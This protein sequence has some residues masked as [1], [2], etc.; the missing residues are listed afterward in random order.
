MPLPATNPAAP[1]RVCRIRGGQTDAQVAL[2][3]E[4]A[5]AN[6]IDPATVDSTNGFEINY[7]DGLI[8]WRDHQTGR[9]QSS[10]LLI[11]PSAEL[12]TAVGRIDQPAPAAPPVRRRGVVLVD[13]DQ[14]GRLLRLPDDWRVLA[15]QPYPM[16]LAIGLLVEGPGLP[17]CHPG[18][19]PPL[20]DTPAPPA[21][22]V[23]Y[24]TAVN[25]I[26]RCAHAGHADPTDETARACLACTRD[27]VVALLTGRRTG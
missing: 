18:A 22:S 25:A 7:G 4:W 20:V 26:E 3:V 10:R 12:L 13:E 9:P 1:L 11:G 14:L 2:I 17:E 27:A 5:R 21:E 15:F 19:E 23:G 6:R 16:R 8:W 24:A